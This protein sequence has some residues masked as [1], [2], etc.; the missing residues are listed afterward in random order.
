VPGRSFRF[1]GMEGPVMIRMAWWA[2][3]LFLAGGCT[4]GVAIGGIAE[5]LEMRGEY[6]EG[7]EEGRWLADHAESAGDGD[8]QSDVSADWIEGL[9]DSLPVLARARE[10]LGAP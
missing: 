1:D 6:A 8:E 3:A 4:L 9:A 5:W 2:A 7:I 10:L